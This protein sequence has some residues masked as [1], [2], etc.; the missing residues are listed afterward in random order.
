L[1]LASDEME[2]YPKYD[3]VLVNNRLEECADHICEIVFS[4]R[5]RRSG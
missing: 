2:F 3:Y 1:A 5:K 4:E